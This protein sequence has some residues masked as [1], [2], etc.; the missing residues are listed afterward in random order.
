[1][2]W[3]NMDLSDSYERD[4]NLIEPLT[5]S[6]LL[7]EVGC[8]CRDIEEATVK[9]QFEEDLQS[10][11]DEAREVFKANLQNIVKRAREER[12]R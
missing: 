7:L 11:I 8:N 1:M 9:A 10:R 4:Q 3:N 12:N 2:N 6:T 5:F